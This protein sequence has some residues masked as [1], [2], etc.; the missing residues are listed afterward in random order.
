M[1]ADITNDGGQSAKRSVTADDRTAPLEQDDVAPATV[2]VLAHPLL[3][4]DT[5]EV[6]AL[7]KE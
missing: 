5:P 3:D 4:T 2:G 6:K 7:A 1:A